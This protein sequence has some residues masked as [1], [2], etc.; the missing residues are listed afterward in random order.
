MW[1]TET[2][3]NNAGETVTVRTMTTN[4]KLLSVSNN[5]ITREN[6]KQ[7]RPATGSWVD[8]KG[9]QRQPRLIVNEGNYTYGMEPNIAY[10]TK[11]VFVPETNT[12]LFIMSHLVQGEEGNDSWFDFGDMVEAGIDLEASTTKGSK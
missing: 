6:G 12:S 10:R 2:Y 3:T 9:I 5:P 7:W 1:S 11:I 4:V 8:Q